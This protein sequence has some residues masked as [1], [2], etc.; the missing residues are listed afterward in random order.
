MLFACLQLNT[1]GR[2]R[3]LSQLVAQ[4]IPRPV[5]NNGTYTGLQLVPVDAVVATSAGM[6]LMQELSAHSQ[7]AAIVAAEASKKRQKARECFAQMSM[8]LASL[9]RQAREAFQTLT[10]LIGATAQMEAT[11]N[12]FR[13]LYLSH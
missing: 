7:S 11:M 9:H 10:T 5:Q 4:A 12:E 8:D 3:S 13:G 6:R 2:R 1:P